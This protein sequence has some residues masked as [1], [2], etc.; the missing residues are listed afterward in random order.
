MVVPFTPPELTRS[1]VRVP[2]SGFGRRGDDRLLDLG[3]VSSLAVAVGPIERIPRGGLV[4]RSRSFLNAIATPIFGGDSVATTNT[5]TTATATPTSDATITATPR[6]SPIRQPK[7]PLPY[8]P[9]ED[10]TQ[11]LPKKQRIITA[12]PCPH[13]SVA[14]AIVVP[15]DARV[16]QTVVLVTKRSEELQKKLSIIQREKEELQKINAELQRKL[17]L[18]QQLFK[19]KKRLTGVVKRLGLKV[20][21]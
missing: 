15:R 21:D 18:F 10:A 9:T 4:G 3:R 19:H 13:V 2:R 1:L 8:E 16:P 14:T 12:S 11:S 7:R 17:S 5:T 6:P 20:V